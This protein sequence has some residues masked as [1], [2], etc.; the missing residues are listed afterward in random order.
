MRLGKVILRA[1]SGRR[2]GGAPGAPAGSGTAVLASATAAVLIG[3]G[4]TGA[5]GRW[6]MGTRGMDA[7][8]RNGLIDA[9]QAVA[10]L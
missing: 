8:F 2:S 7:L 3:E 10:A 9:A 4:A 6:L 5:N 1:D